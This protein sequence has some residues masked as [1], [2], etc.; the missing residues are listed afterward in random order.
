MYKVTARVLRFKIVFI[1]E[2]TCYFSLIERGFQ[3]RQYNLGED[4][5]SV[6][7]YSK[8]EASFSGTPR[9]KVQC[10]Q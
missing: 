1:A 9:H 10:L 5:H 4:T 3:K 6:L 7:C 2:D 8:K